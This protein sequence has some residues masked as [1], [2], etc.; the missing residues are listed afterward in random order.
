MTS[1][2]KIN[3]KVYQGSTFSQTLRWESSSKI[4]VPITNISRT[5]PMIVT[6]P[7]HEVPVGWRA[8]ISGAVG[9]KE[10]NSLDYIIAT[11]VTT[12][13]ITFNSIN[14]LTFGIYTGGGVL[15]YNQPFELGLYTARMQIRAKLED[16]VVIKELTTEN[17]GIIINN[18]NKTILL[19]ISAVD[20]TLFTF[21]TAVYSLE[22]VN[23]NIVLPFANGNLSLVKE[24]TR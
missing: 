24:V 12:D 17:G 9:M 5:A 19:F 7:Y 20:T 18:S 23:G 15:E 2:A 10:V 21:Q 3:F 6:A 13:T 14:S 8:K 1:P 11:H 22:L 16:S 4:Y